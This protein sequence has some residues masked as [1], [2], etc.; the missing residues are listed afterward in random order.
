MSVDFRIIPLKKMFS[1][2]YNEEVYKIPCKVISLGKHLRGKEY[3]IEIE[4]LD[5]VTAEMKRLKG[6]TY[7]GSLQY[8]NTFPFF[9]ECVVRKL[10]KN[11]FKLIVYGYFGTGV[12][13]GL[14]GVREILNNNE[15]DITKLYN[16]YYTPFREW[17][18]VSKTSDNSTKLDDDDL[19]Y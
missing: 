18:G 1:D 15:E 10:G 12:I 11:K 4:I 7:E 6:I 5:F 2:F 19:P 17:L 13:E 3:E 9:T 16:H 8:F 14:F